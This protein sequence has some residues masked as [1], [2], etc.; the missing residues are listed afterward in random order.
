MFLCFLFQMHFSSTNGLES[1]VALDMGLLWVSTMFTQI[2]YQRIT[3][4]LGME[5]W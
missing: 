2:T 3:G 1:D 4:H 5:T